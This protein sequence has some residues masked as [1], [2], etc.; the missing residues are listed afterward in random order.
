[1]EKQTFNQVTEQISNAYIEGNDA[2]PSV[3]IKRSDG[4]VTVGRL[5][6]DT[7]NVHFSEDG[8]S[9][10]HGNVPVERLSDTYQAE[11]A[12]EL[13]GK[14]LR[15]RL[16]DIAIS[17]A[18]HQGREAA[19]AS[20]HPEE[21]EAALRQQIDSLLDR[22]SKD[23]KDRLF[24]YTLYAS[25]KEKAQSEDDGDASML[26][27]Q[28][29]GQEYIAMSQDARVIADRYHRLMGQLSRTRQQD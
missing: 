29:M 4:R 12:E 18:T 10:M 28:Y 5:D 14:Q 26:A 27:G 19:K 11:L 1:M 23:D 21:R 8:K 9:K 3:L 17:S 15:S 6:P 7:Q 25:D 2:L 20:Q 22:L 24:R 13:A 16:G